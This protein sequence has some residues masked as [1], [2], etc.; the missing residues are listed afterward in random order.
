MMKRYGCGCA[1]QIE[2]A[3]P[4]DVTVWPCEP[5]CEV[6]PA[7][8]AACSGEQHEV[9]ILEDEPAPEIDPQKHDVENL[10]I[11]AGRVD[12]VPSTDELLKAID[13]LFRWS[14]NKRTTVGAGSVI[15]GVEMLLTV[16]PI[17]KHNEALDDAL[18][19]IRDHDQTYGP[20][21]NRLN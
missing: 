5:D 7:I 4:V 16:A 13:V 12:E 19:Q 6:I 10:K 17:E 18:R 8:R 20:S 15:Q 14:I 11:E 3:H 21:G 9:Q 1:L 2:G